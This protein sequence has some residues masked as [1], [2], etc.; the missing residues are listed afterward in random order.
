MLEA[1]T[2]SPALRPSW[3]WEGWRSRDGA[4][5]TPPADVRQLAQRGAEGPW[6]GA[7]WLPEEGLVLVLSRDRYELDVVELDDRWAVRRE[8]WGCPSLSPDSVQ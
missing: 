3:F 5:C 2:P 7:M 6:S 8:A 4:S 1:R